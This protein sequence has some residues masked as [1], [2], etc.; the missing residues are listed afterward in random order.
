[1]RI[2]Y[3]SMKFPYERQYS[4]Y[5]YGGSTEAAYYLAV[6]IAKRNHQV[7]I[8]TTSRD[9]HNQDEMKS[10]ISIHRYGTNFRILSAN[11][12][13]S[14]FL[15]PVENK[16]D[17]SHTHF[18]IPPAPIA[19]L[20]YKIKN[21]V[22]L[23]VTYHG[24][25]EEGYGNPFRQYAITLTNRLLVNKV[26]ESADLII[27]P[28]RS[29]ARISRFLNRFQEKIR[30]IPNGIVMEKFALMTPIEELRKRLGFHSD[31]KII[32]FFGYLSPYKSPDILLKAFAK[33][34]QVERNT[35]LIYVGDGVM[36]NDLQMM[37]GKLGLADCVDFKGFVNEDMKASYL[38]STDVFCLPSTMRTECYPI[39]ILEAMASG[40]P[41][42]A[43][44]IGGIPDIINDNENGL[45]V[46]PG[47]VEA[48]AN[49][50]L[51]LVRSEGLRRR[52]VGNAS[53][54]IKEHT[55]ERIAEQTERIYKELL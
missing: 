41:V 10:K 55:W 39:A 22:P 19:G 42:I 46:D 50:I 36:R 21:D 32:L 54:W 18:D 31:E 5:R 34:H 26:L 51:S 1:M 30:I 28:S 33:I 2:G 44:R 53:I 6:E 40:A 37:A 16:V 27:S 23:V 12:S 4:N 29:Y 25:W 20:L 24:D 47:N 48:L 3:F 17:L 38:K 13:F 43:S 8:F 35:R 11:I 9:S 7:D 15:R 45:L 49:S 14:Q 52:L